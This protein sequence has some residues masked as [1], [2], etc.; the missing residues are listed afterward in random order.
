MLRGTTAVVEAEKND[1]CS[2][3]TSACLEDF[4]ERV[5]L[6]AMMA[7]HG[8]ACN[9]KIEESA[10]SCLNF[11]SHSPFQDNCL[12]DGSQMSTRR[13]KEFWAKSDLVLMHPISSAKPQASSAKLTTMVTSTHVS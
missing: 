3:S 10:V 5:S 2:P 4:V 8:N 13:S 12:Q 9:A 6:Q 11:R 1:G 7:T